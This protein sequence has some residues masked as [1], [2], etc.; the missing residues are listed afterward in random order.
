MQDT[1]QG[2]KMDLMKLAGISHLYVDVREKG[3]CTIT[4]YYRNDIL[5]T[6]VGRGA[7]ETC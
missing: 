2:V 7:L 3:T 6:L 1:G 4:F 5:G